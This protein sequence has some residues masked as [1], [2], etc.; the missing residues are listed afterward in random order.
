[1][2]EDAFD[3][4]RITIKPGDIL[5]VRVKGRL[6][7]EMHD[8]ILDTMSA[9]LAKAGHPDTAVVVTPEEIGFAVIEK[10]PT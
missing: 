6:T 8:R 10:E 9:A 2:A 3:V 1:M 5:A 7:L 4:Q